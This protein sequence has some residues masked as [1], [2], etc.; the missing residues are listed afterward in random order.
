MTSRYCWRPK[1]KVTLTL[2]PAANVSVI[3]GPASGVPGILISRLGW[4]TVFQRSAAS[5]TVASVSCARPG[6]TSIETRP[7]TVPLA[8][9]A[10][11][12]ISQALRTSSVVIT[13]T[14]WSR[15]VPSPASSRICASYRSPWLRAAWKIDGLVVTPTT[16]WSRTRSA[17]LPVSM[18]SRD[19]SS[20]QI[21]TPASESCFR[22]SVMFPSLVGASVGG[23]PDA[24]LGRRGD[25]LGGDAELLVEAGEVG[26]R[27]VVLERD[28]PPAVAHD[29]APALR[30]PGLHR[31]P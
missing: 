18:R 1:I 6:D 19:R 11:R 26:G 22:R 24:V 3:A 20:S 30:H 2:M 9:Y 15:S 12:M 27:A 16:C 31:D 8:S 23:A 7:S 5:A 17:R 14:A 25:G 21:E 13:R 10:G 4:S 29:L 28:D